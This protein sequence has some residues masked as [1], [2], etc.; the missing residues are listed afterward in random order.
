VGEQKGNHL[1]HKNTKLREQAE[2]MPKGAGAHPPE[3]VHIQS[4]DGHRPDRGT[5]KQ[6]DPILGP[7]EM[8]VPAS[9]AWVEERNNLTAIG[10]NTVNPRTLGE[11]TGITAKSKVVG[12]V[13][14]TAT[15]RHDMLIVKRA[16]GE[17]LRRVTI[18]TPLRRPALHEPPEVVR[19]VRHDQSAAL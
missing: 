11:I 2:P 8:L 4:A 19:D 18:L 14:A 10:I 15:A 17:K 3:A 12:I 1:R 16:I 6:R 7:H 9:A 13:D 5:P